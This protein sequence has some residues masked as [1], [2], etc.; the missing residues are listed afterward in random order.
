MCKTQGSYRERIEN[1]SPTYLQESK[2]RN[3][4]RAMDRI[5]RAF[6]M[7]S[8]QQCFLFLGI[9]Q[10]SIGKG[11]AALVCPVGQGFAGR[12]GEMGQYVGL[13]GGSCEGHLGGSNGEG[14]PSGCPDGSVRAQ[15]LKFLPNGICFHP[16]PQGILS[17][18]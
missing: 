9:I 7:L 1:N 10:S 5:K 17:Y 16:G 3:S 2:T 13:R 15:L 4:E 8:D 14:L 6:C 12:S 18:I 11:L